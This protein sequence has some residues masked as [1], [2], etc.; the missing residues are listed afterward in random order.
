[1]LLTQHQRKPSF[2]CTCALPFSCLHMHFAVCCLLPDHALDFDNHILHF[3]VLSVVLALL[4]SWGALARVC[5]FLWLLYNCTYYTIVPCKESAVFVKLYLVKTQARPTPPAV[6]H[7][8]IAWIKH[9]IIFYTFWRSRVQA[10]SDSPCDQ[11]DIAMLMLLSID[12]VY[13][14]DKLDRVVKALFQ[15]VQYS[16]RPAYNAQMHIIHGL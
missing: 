3:P 16:N 9:S 13:L 8:Y 14:K 10:Q 7:V 2:A 11:L 6:T 1:M 12:I 4:L 5:S 15:R